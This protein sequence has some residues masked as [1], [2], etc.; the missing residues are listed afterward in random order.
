M[1]TTPASAKLKE[2]DPIA[3]RIA[4]ALAELATDPAFKL[5]NCGYTVVRARGKGAGTI[6]ITGAGTI[7][8]SGR[9]LPR[10]VTRAWERIAIAA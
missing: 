6:A 3:A 4:E 7:S 5:G 9:C 10:D 1:T 8:V 2:Q